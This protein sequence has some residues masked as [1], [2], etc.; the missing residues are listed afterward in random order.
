MTFLYPRR[1]ATIIVWIV[2]VYKLLIL[3]RQ[4]FAQFI[5]SRFLCMYLFIP[6]IQRM[7]SFNTFMHFIF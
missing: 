1:T 5:F 6:T 7:I 3:S 4:V 2:W